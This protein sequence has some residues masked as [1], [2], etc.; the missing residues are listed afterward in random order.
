ME[1]CPLA[2]EEIS[3]ISGFLE[4]WLV[5][6][7]LESRTFISKF[8]ISGGRGHNNFIFGWIT[9]LKNYAPWIVEDLNMMSDIFIYYIVSVIFSISHYE[10]LHKLH[11]E[12]FGS[13]CEDRI[14][15]LSIICV[16]TD[17]L[18]DDDSD[19]YRNMVMSQM[20]I[21]LKSIITGNPV[22]LSLEIDPK[23]ESAY[24][25]L[26]SLIKDVPSCVPQM[27]KAFEFEANSAKQDVERKESYDSISN[28]ESKKGS[29]T[30]QLLGVILN[31]GKELEVPDELGIALQFYDDLTDVYID[32][33]SGISTVATLEIEKFGFVD[34][35]VYE[36]FL[37]IDKLSPKYWPFK[38][39]IAFCVS[40]YTSHSIYISDTLSRIM[41]PYTPI[42]SRVKI[43]D[44]FPM[45][46]NMLE[47]CFR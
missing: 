10:I 42:N 8:L 22:D 33:N 39:V 43:D 38:I 34:R 21:L 24:K 31:N 7:S 23:V 20:K 4:K 9:R 29:S 11:G 6:I 36:I 25:I 47:R 46:K 27:V 30:Y 19:E 32:R 26:K 13:I 12:N 28:I 17:K 41:L 35:I 40:L 16:V 2:E 44:D 15:R 1:K 18:F 45:I 37:C 3:L 5:E 14:M